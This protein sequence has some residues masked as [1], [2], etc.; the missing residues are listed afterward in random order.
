M[1]DFEKICD[2]TFLYRA[3][4]KARKGKRNK[5]DVMAFELNLSHHLS[6]LQ[7]MLRCG[8]YQMSGYRHFQVYEPKK[9]DI[10]EVDHVDKVVM[11][12]LC[13]E[14]SL[15]RLSSHFIYD[16]AACQKGKG[17]HFA[18]RRFTKF[19]YEGFRKNGKQFYVL[20]CDISK[21]FANINH[22]VLKK[23]L[24]KKDS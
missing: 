3:H 7:D 11:H 10:Y 23:Q 16:N 21:Y 18:M 13:D 24:T 6:V 12:V 17:T 4:L 8:T 2:F 20:K 1:T 9:R 22:D 15:P 5:R 19:L 14:V